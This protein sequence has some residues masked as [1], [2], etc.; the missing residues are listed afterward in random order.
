MFT[1]S[2]SSS[3]FPF[4]IK[5]F[6]VILSV[7]TAV[8]SLPL[9]VFS[10]EFRN[11]VDELK[12]D[13]LPEGLDVLDAASS[14]YTSRVPSLE[15][16][17]FSYVF[18]K[19]DGTYECLTYDY[20]VKYYDSEGALKDKT[21]LYKEITTSSGTCYVS[22]DNDIVTSV[23]T[24]LSDGISIR[25]GATDVR[26]VYAGASTGSA[27]PGNASADSTDG[28]SAPVSMSPDMRRASYALSQNTGLEYT[29]TFN[30]FKEEIVVEEYNGVTDYNFFLYTN[31]I[32]LVEENE[33]FRLV[34][35][36]GTVRAQIGRII[37]FT[38]DEK[39]NAFGDMY[40]ETVENNNVYRLTIHIEEEYLSSPDTAYPIR[41]DPSVEI[42]YSS[43]GSGA[44]E[45]ITVSDGNTYAGSATY[46]FV[47]KSNG[48]KYRTLVKF[49]NLASSILGKNIVSASYEIRDI[50]C[51]SA[52]LQIECRRYTS[53][54]WREETG[55]SWNQAVSSCNGELLDTQYVFYGNGNVYGAAHRY[56]FDITSLAQKW[57]SGEY[58]T[59]EGIVLK[60][61]YSVENGTGNNIK[62]FASFNRG[63]YTPSFRYSWTEA[64]GLN[65]VWEFR[66]RQTG[67]GITA[68]ENILF[69]TVVIR[70]AFN[71][72]TLNEFPLSSDLIFNSSYG[73]ELF[74][75]AGLDSSVYGRFGAGWK[76]GFVGICIRV[77]DSYGDPSQYCYIDGTGCEYY[78]TY[79]S[80]RNR[81]ENSSLDAVLT[82]DSG[83][84]GSVTLKYED[85]E[86]HFNSAGLLT[87]VVSGKKEYTYNYSGS[88]LSSISCGNK[89]LIS[90][91]YSGSYL[92]SV[93][94]RSC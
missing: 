48:K 56:S 7:L 79:N 51:E 82:I 72:P 94:F 47:G 23:P 63:A 68:Y 31:G 66:T 85:T 89:T 40:A 32:S 38:A 27:V 3:R 50:A 41:I 17:L 61:V 74:D 15:E 88:R 83:S 4:G 76:P 92:S 8:L 81:F 71:I 34:D 78:F 9:Y 80:D 52:S 69:G 58:S 33:D 65:S 10:A 55:I 39:N 16:D 62:T 22:A 44:I 54:N 29:L 18:S 24:I 59:E 36:D 28:I 21:N 30:G 19:T 70:N 53:N 42:C 20:P 57:A 46:L 90:L 14:G 43:N 49:P 25:Y 45:D 11:A 1:R 5:A 13:D 35:S 6:S 60:A 67:S 84:T 73:E 2:Q 12:A 87:S 86:R 93:S 37:V 91:S 75:K 64:S 77:N 26:M